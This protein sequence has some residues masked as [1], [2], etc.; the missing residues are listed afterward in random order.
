MP[1]RPRSYPATPSGCCASEGIGS[2]RLAGSAGAA[3]G[4]R[5]RRLSTPAGSGFLR[6]LLRGFRR[7]A[8]V[9]G[10]LAL[11]GGDA[12]AQRVHEADDVGGA[13]RRRGLLDRLVVLL[14]LD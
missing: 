13:R 10:G 3:F 11:V 1:T 7:C 9:V 12:L 4:R 14:R 5:P 8:L 6:A 2:A